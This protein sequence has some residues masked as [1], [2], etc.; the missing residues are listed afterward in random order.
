MSEAMNKRDEIKVLLVEDR[1]DDAELLLAEMRR[2][3]LPVVSLR[4]EGEPAYTHALR[5]FAPRLILSDYTL[6]D[7]DGPLALRIARRERPDTPFIFVSGTIGEERAIDALQQGA[8]DYVLKDSRARG[9]GGVPRGATPRA[10]PTRGERTTISL[11]LGSHAG[12]DLGN[13]LAGRLH[14]LESGSGN[15]DRLQT[16]GGP[17]QKLPRSGV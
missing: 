7:F 9:G 1:T 8:V 2:R 4:V 15:D 6:P 10:P 5:H 11:N 14:I 17:R 3:G 13:G 12:V 16:A